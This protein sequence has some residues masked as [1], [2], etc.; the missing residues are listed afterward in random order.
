V[1]HVIQGTK[2]M[3]YQAKNTVTKHSIAQ[4]IA[5]KSSVPQGMFV[6]RNSGDTEGCRES[7]IK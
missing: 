1:P 2:L 5:V 6:C 7:V 3:L 4:C